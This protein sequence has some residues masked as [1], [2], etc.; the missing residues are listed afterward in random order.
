MESSK[1]TKQYPG[2]AEKRP[3]AKLADGRGPSGRQRPCQ[4]RSGPKVSRGAASE[5]L[6]VQRDAGNQRPFFAPAL[7]PVIPFQARKPQ[8]LATVEFIPDDREA[9]VAQ[10]DPN[11]MRAAG[12][13]RAAEQRPARKF[14]QHGKKRVRALAGFRVHPPTVMPSPAPPPNPPDTDAPTDADADA[15]ALTPKLA[16]ADADALTPAVSPAEAPAPAPALRLKP[17]LALALT[18]PLGSASAAPV[19]ATRRSSRPLIWATRLASIS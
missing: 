13:R 14:F 6:G 1:V 8:R 9:R 16:E 18:P 12:T 15:D 7:P 17:A 4:G 3:C 19:G 5:L 10:V 11:L 2:K